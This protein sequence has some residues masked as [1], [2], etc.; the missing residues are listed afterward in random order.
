MF[1]ENLPS[2]TFGIMR[3]PVNDGNP[4]IFLF[5]VTRDVFQGYVGIFIRHLHHLIS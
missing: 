5:W 2:N 4:F 3:P 1:Q